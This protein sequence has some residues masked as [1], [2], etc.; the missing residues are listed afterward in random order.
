MRVQ[1]FAALTVLVTTLNAGAHHAV[2]F[3]VPH[4]RAVFVGRML[5]QNRVVVFDDLCCVICG[6]TTTDRHLQ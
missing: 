3:P 5:A 1:Y 2:A 4:S 6:M